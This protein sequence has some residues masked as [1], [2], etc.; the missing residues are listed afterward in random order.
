MSKNINCKVLDPLL[1]F[2]SDKAQQTPSLTIANKSQS[3]KTSEQFGL[4][5]Y[6]RRRKRQVEVNKARWSMNKATT[7]LE[8]KEIETRKK[9]PHGNF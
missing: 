6:P 8:L 2:L 3:L 4:D 1:I 7:M 9:K 5:T